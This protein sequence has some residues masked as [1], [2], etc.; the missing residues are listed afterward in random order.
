MKFIITFLLAFVAVFARA[1]TSPTVRFDSIAD[2]VAYAIPSVNSKLSAIVS[3]KAAT[4]DSFLA[5]EFAYSS[6]STLS[7]NT[8][9]VFKPLAS[10][11]RWIRITS[12]SWNQSPN[13]A[14]PA[15]DTSYAFQMERGVGTNVLAMGA[16]A[17]NTII[18]T[19]SSSP[20]FINPIGANNL[21]LNELG[22]NV[23]IQKTVPTALL[24]VGAGTTSNPSIKFTAGTLTTTPQ[25]GAFEYNGT[26]L[27]FTDQTETRTAVGG[28]SIGDWG[29][30][31]GT[32]TGPGTSSILTA[33]ALS[34]GTSANQPL[35]FKIN[36]T[37]YGR[38]A[39]GGN[40]GIGTTGPDKKLDILD[41]SNAQLRLSQA[42][43]TVYTDYQT[44]STGTTLSTNSAGH[45]TTS[46]TVNDTSVLARQVQGGLAFDGVAATTAD[47]HTITG[48]IGTSDL[49]VSTTFTV[50]TTAVGG[51]SVYLWNLFTSASERSYMQMLN[52]TLYLSTTTAGSST[53]TVIASNFQTTYSGKTVTITAVRSGVSGTTALWT[54]YL[55]GVQVYSNTPT[56]SGS[57]F[58]A[59]TIFYAG[60][61]GAASQAMNAGPIFAATLFN[62]ALSA[63]E[64]VTLANQGVQEADK[65]GSL[66]AA[67]NSNRAG[68][69]DTS[70]DSWTA[71]A[72]TTTAP[73]T[74]DA[75]DNT[76]RIVTTAT[77]STHSSAKST[78]TIGKKY[79]ASY[80]YYFPSGNSVVTGFQL[81]QGGSS[82]LDTV[83]S[84]V[85]DT[86]TTRTVSVFTATNLN[87]TFYL[88]AGA[89]SSFAANGTDAMYL[90][91][92]TFTQVGSIL[93]ADLS[94]GVG[95]QV[96]DRSSNK[97]HGVVSATGTAWTLPNRRGQIRYTT[98]GATTGAFQLLSSTAIPANALIQSI[99]AW[100]AGTPLVY[101][102]NATGT[103]NIA[104]HT[105]LA[106]STYTKLA[107]TNDFSTTGNLWLNKSATNEVNLTVNYMIAD[108]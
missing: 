92:V 60:S 27:Y 42:D 36:G 74:Q 105:T 19:F 17:T 11:G 45:R 24:H 31:T 95:Y 89:S 4:G 12:A 22:G 54:I 43:G 59:N 67:Y 37:E 8:F 83:A 9:S 63:A 99:V 96:P 73:I 39:T 48:T 102:G 55:N 75:E 44:L 107:L 38:V 94:A 21:V 26:T 53:S 20:L 46:T 3:G 23:G 35:I 32:I 47:A 10:G 50:Q 56:N 91:D 40:I 85:L 57:N 61:Y 15:D 41:A 84:P 49:S 34:V 79:K 64:V 25:A 68:G 2:M 33:G 82:V 1:Q 58:A 29:F 62:R 71:N 106:A 28:T 30:G 78:L 93:D 80:R 7:T 65:W 103:S 77:T 101:V 90:K 98:T 69:W 16:T 97:Y 88:F 51:T 81:W 86:W 76:M 52:D 100:S 70:T 5:G 108:P 87:P 104:V 6:S 72:V 66:T 13:I 18:Q 14:N